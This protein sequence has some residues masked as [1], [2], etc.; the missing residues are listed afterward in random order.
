MTRTIQQRVEFP[1]G[2]LVKLE[3][4]RYI[5]VQP[6]LPRQISMF[7]FNDEDSGT[8]MAGINRRYPQTD[9]WSCSQVLP[10]YQPIPYNTCDAESYYKLPTWRSPDSELSRAAARW[11]IYHR[12]LVQPYSASD[13]NTYCLAR[14]HVGQND[15]QDSSAWSTSLMKYFKH[16]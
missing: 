5:S 14:Q 16:Y 15:A 11:C 8:I 10:R 6:R 9:H 1:V 12:F 4:P 7:R 2:S 3:R 13:R